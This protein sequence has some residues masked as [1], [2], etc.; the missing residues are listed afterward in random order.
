MG[1]RGRYV[2]KNH[3]DD[4]LTRS[5]MAGACTSCHMLRMAAWT[6]RTE[7]FR[8]Q[9]KLS[10]KKLNFVALSNPSFYSLK[11]SLLINILILYMIMNRVRPNILSCPADEVG[12]GQSR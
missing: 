6:K 7:V 3:P 1:H 4:S 5:R 2:G 10:N 8:S 9:S 12:R 11:L